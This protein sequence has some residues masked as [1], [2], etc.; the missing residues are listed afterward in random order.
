MK[1]LILILSLA[2]STSIFAQT[3]M[4]E[5]VDIIQGLYGKSKKELVGSYMKLN[6]ADAAGFWKTYDAYE[7]DRK[8]LGRKKIQL[9]NDYANNYATL[10]DEKA[11]EIATASL[12]NN[13][14][15]EMLFMKYYK[16][17]RKELGA[18]N[19]AKFIQLEIYLQTAV[20]T[21][22]QNAIPFIGEMENSMPQSTH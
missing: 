7:V 16:K 12:K 22:I 14:E 13:M 18:L 8:E 3:T 20:R 9:I 4:K 5:D 10:T 1:K 21:E 2:I 17:T 11:D 19:A 15:Y 6:E